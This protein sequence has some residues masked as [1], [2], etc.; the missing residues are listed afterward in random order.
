[1]RVR[2]KQAKVEQG[3]TLVE[4]MIAMV[5][6]GILMIMVVS[7]LLQI[8]GIYNK[9]VALKQI[10]EV[11][12]Q[13]VGDVSQLGRNG[14]EAAVND[15]GKA[16]YL[17]V[18]QGAKWR[19]YTWNS[20]GAGVGGRLP[21]VNDA[22]YTLGGNPISLARSNETI[23]GEA[24]GYCVLPNPTDVAMDSTEVTSLLTKQVRILSVDIVSTD[25]AFKKITFWVGTY[26]DDASSTNI[27]TQNATTKA[28][29][30]ENKRLGD[31]CAVAKFE[32]VLYVGNGE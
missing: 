3:F 15:N 28:W 22:L 24:E 1:M 19:S 11:G 27:P 6:V 14:E 7:V 13:I 10:N 16:G 2:V 12:R 30:C 8:V 31:F 29:S 25:P 23:D 4:L 17:C 5:F 32:T 18:R 9:A 20:V 21:D 26:N